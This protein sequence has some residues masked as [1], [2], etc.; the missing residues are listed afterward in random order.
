MTQADVSV[1]RHFNREFT[2][3]IG[4]LEDR[5]LG[6]GRPLGPARLLFEIGRSGARVLDLRARL[7][8]DSG[9]LS[10]LL[11]GLEAEGLVRVEPDPTDRRRRFATLTS[12]GRKEWDELEARSER[13]AQRLVEPLSA[14]HRARLDAA[15]LTAERI[16]ASAAASFDPVDPR[17][18]EAVWAVEQYIG[19]LDERFDAGFDAGD[20]LERE[21]P[22]Y[23]PPGGVFILARCDGVAIGCAG[24]CTLEPGVGEIKRMWVSPDHR[25]AGL[26][27]R[28]LTELEEQSR[29]LGHRR[30]RLDTH[31]S[32]TEAIEMYRRGGY[33]E[34]ACYN[35]NPYAELWFEKKLDG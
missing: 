7:G 24:L 31:R 26:G 12:R 6:Q 13:F 22:H 27:P 18:P 4:V 25:G 20:A 28:L 2:H 9:Y 19:E 1:L 3:R 14:T 8:L 16:L 33:T 32:L 21:A 11:R 29:R 15:L 34:V 30:V 35:D 5:F 17:S 23:D 10:R